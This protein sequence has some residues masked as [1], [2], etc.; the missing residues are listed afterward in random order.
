VVAVFFWTTPSPGTLALLI[1]VGACAVVGQIATSRAFAVADATA[2]LP[3]DFL[4]FGMIIAIGWAAFGESVDETTMIGGAVIIGS[5]IY[6]AYREAVAARRVRAT[7][8]P[9]P[10]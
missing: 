8:L 9:P 6:L 7:A 5:S 3:Y 2:V 1:G 10:T 4:R